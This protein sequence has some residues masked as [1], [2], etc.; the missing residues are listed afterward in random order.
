MRG[1]S[2][3]EQ[4]LKEASRLGMTEAVVPAS[5]KLSEN[6][7]RMKIVHVHTLSEAISWL[8]DKK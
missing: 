5:C 3:L 8:M 4:R 7:G 6:V 1:V 2:L